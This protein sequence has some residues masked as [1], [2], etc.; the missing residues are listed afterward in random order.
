[1]SRDRESR[2]VAMIAIASRDSS[3][4][5]RPVATPDILIATFFSADFTSTESVSMKLPKASLAAPLEA[6]I[7]P[8]PSPRE[9]P[10][11]IYIGDL[12]GPR[13][14]EDDHARLRRT[15]RGTAGAKETT[16]WE[17]EGE[18]TTHGF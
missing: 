1:M 8:A 13:I 10:Q 2:C 7:S 14:S 15:S 12:P 9:S 16:E 5:V 11:H 17:P 18:E 3:R 4:P 6:E